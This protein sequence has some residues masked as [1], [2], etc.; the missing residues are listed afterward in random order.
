MAKLGR[1]YIQGEDC[2]LESQQSSVADKGGAAPDCSS[3]SGRSRSSSSNSSSSSSRWERM[4][5]DDEKE[6]LIGDLNSALAS[7]WVC[8]VGSP[9]L[10]EGCA[11]R[12]REMGGKQKI[13]HEI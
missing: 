4:G 13:V 1:N 9:F 5:D 2:R 12:K 6:N 11:F 10:E 7:Q 8:S 3:S